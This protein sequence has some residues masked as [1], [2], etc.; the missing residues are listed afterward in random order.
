MA[1]TF[2]TSSAILAKAGI[3]HST[4]L[5]TGW[6]I[7]SVYDD[8]ITEADATCVVMSRYDY[9]ASS[10]AITT[11]ALPLIKGVVSDLAAIQAV[12]YDMSTGYTDRIEAE[13]VITILRDSAM[14]GLQLI[15]DQKG[16][17]F[18]K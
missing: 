5:D 18:T 17:T 9:V 2:A 4:D 6:S 3:G 14:R 15:R 1:G 11:N 7:G 12:K 8:W 13:D 16:V 10:A